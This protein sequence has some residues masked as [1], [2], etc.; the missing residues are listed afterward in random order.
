VTPLTTKTARHQR[1]IDVLSRSVVHT[2]DELREAL[3]ASGLDVTQATLSRDLVELGATKV[4]AEDGSAI[5]A[6]SDPGSLTSSAAL[7]PDTDSAGR[8]A[9]VTAEVMTGA[10]FA[11]NIV[12]LHTK[13]GAANYLAGAIDRN[14]WPDVLGSVAGDDTVIVVARTNESAESMCEALLALCSSKPKKK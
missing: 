11:N 9:R 1:I 12:V 10:D 5:Y 14:A 3:L 7:G 13:P 8:L 6:I 2:Q 4:I